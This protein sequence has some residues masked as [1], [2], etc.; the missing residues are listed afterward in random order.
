MR[1]KEGTYVDEPLER[2]DVTVLRVDD[3]GDDVAPLQL[4]GRKVRRRGRQR[5]RRL[6]PLRALVL[7]HH[8]ALLLDLDN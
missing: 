1:K 7:R 8:P 2:G 6:P 3:R 5:R 4:L